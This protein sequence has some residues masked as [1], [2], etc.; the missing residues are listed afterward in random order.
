MDN[1]TREQAAWRDL[2]PPER[3]PSA[4]RLRTIEERLMDEVVNDEGQSHHPRRWVVAAAAATVVLAVIGVRLAD[5]AGDS[6]D[7]VAGDQPDEESAP[8][9]DETPD[10]P[11]EIELT[12]EMVEAT[13]RIVAP[14]D[15]ASMQENIRLHGRI[16]RMES[17]AVDDCVVEEGLPPREVWG[18]AA[19]PWQ[20]ADWNWNTMYFPDL[21]LLLEDGFRPEPATGGSNI[22][23]GVDAN[24]YVAVEM[25]CLE[26][27][28]ETMGTTTTDIAGDE[29]YGSWHQVIEEVFQSDEV[30]DLQL[31]YIDC[32]RDGGVPEPHSDGV[33]DGGGADTHFGIS[34]GMMQHATSQPNTNEILDGWAELYVG[35]GRPWIERRE[36]LLVEDGR[37]EEFLREHAGEIDDLAYDLAQAGLF[38]DL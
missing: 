38:D 22:P 27:V 6:P 14:Y 19:E 4:E 8:P 7:T 24:E 11:P 37:R 5:W 28:R 1:R 3:L 32:L 12:P 26:Q 15:T 23:D 34:D 10:D 21:D 29:T 36:E 31:D 13:E 33:T 18:V 17:D 16:Q 30:R 20:E 2:L 35:C 9:D 25:E